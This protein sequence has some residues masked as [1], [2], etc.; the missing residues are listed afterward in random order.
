MRSSSCFSQRVRAGA[1]AGLL[2]FSLHA[3][4]QTR[5]WVVTGTIVTADRVFADG[6]LSISG[7]KITAVGERA[8]LPGNAAVTKLDGIVL[9]GFIDLHNHL[10]WNVHPRWIPNRKFSNRY[11][12]QNTA[13]Y[14]R[15][16]AG[17]HAALGG[18]I[19]EAEIFGEVKALIGGATSVVGS[20][21]PDKLGC[22]RGLLRNLDVDSGLGPAPAAGEACQKNPKAP[23]A[24][25][26]LVVNDVFPLE[27][28][29]ERM[30]FLRCALG[31][32]AMRS[33]VVHLSEGAD[34]S[35]RREFRM[36]NKTGLIMPGLV[37]VH[38]TA[39]RAEDFQVMGEKKAGL[40]WSPRSNDELYGESSNIAA[41]L[42]QNVA[43]A[44]AP[45]WSPTGSAGML[46]EIGYAGRR[47]KNVT[48]EQLIAMGTSAPARMARLDDRIGALAPGLM[49][50][51]IVLH[52]DKDKPHLAAVRATPADVQLVVVGGRPMYGD[53]PVMARLLPGVKLE[54]LVVCGAKKSLYLGD[55]AAAAPR[56]SF[57][58]IQSKL[59]AVLAKAGASL[60]GF[61]CN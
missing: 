45:D 54:S 30:N 28:D 49:A 19:C 46:Q 15:V 16:L 57:A 20:L 56:R 5:D 53:A 41:A 26:D 38:G 33:L 10:T 59:A 44:I 25:F 2:M 52:G 51:F 40:V 12:W 36:L 23:Q 29:Y 35:A 32:G 37:V 60:A 3:G 24:L 50:D 31:S 48:P 11:E 8:A 22:S 6:A 14:D 21:T 39:L 58:D 47:Y 9:P 55:S 1:A 4:A 43:V 42:Q 18:A 7:D 17:P 27:I 13:E 61:E 34:A